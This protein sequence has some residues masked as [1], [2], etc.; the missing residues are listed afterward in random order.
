MT[1]DTFLLGT[2]VGSQE[3]FEYLNSITDRSGNCGSSP[4]GYKMCNA[5]YA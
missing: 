2:T 5:K 1:N 4:S 3:C